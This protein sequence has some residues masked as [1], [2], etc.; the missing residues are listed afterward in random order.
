MTKC[1]EGHVYSGTKLMEIV[2]DI[3]SLDHT[4]VSW[5]LMSLCCVM[6]VCRYMYQ[7]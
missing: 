7:S 5:L 2:V 6:L 1:P 4:L 3:I